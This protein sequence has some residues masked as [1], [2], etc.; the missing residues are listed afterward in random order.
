MSGIGES[1]E[2]F[3]SKPE[4][5]S[6]HQK[7]MGFMRSVTRRSRDYIKN[8]GVKVNAWELDRES[9]EVDPS[10]TL[11]RARYVGDPDNYDQVRIEVIKLAGLF[12]V[13]LYQRP[14]LERITQTEGK[15]EKIGC[16]DFLFFTGSRQDL[17][18]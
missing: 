6:H 11:V 3:L 12:H 14:E 5:L 2:R 17:L 10:M 8:Y 16:D 18:E 13:V 9:H 15:K 1:A 7:A 4:N